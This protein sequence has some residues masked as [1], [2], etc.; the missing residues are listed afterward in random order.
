MLLDVFETFTWILTMVDVEHHKSGGFHQ[1]GF[2]L[3]RL[4][5]SHISDAGQTLLR[6]NV[7]FAVCLT[8][9]LE[10]W[11]FEDLLQSF[12]VELGR[13]ATAALSCLIK[14]KF[15]TKII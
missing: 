7:T 6:F 15:H 9:F 3:T 4:R 2:A 12:V 10:A 13:S 5:T 14:I 11:I 8:L 1:F